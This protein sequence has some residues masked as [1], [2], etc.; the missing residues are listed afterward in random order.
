[1]HE[2]SHVLTFRTRD[3]EKAWEAF[4]RNP[5]RAVI[6]L[7]GDGT[8][9]EIVKYPTMPNVDPRY[10]PVLDR[11]IAQTGVTGM[12][13]GRSVEQVRSFGLLGEGLQVL[14]QFGCEWWHH[15]RL[16]LPVER[17]ATLDVVDAMLPE[18]FAKAGLADASIE[19]V[20]SH[21]RAIHYAAG[22]DDTTVA[23]LV[24]GL[25]HLAAKTGL[26]CLPG[27]NVIEL[28]PE[29]NKRDALAWF[30][31]ALPWEPSVVLYAGDS[32]PDLAAF[33]VLDGLRSQGVP[34]LKV[35][36]SDNTAVKARSDLLVRGPLGTL[37][38]LLRLCAL[39]SR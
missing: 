36:T 18:V 23:A 13:T 22:T 15:G 33:D 8:M 21:F 25:T 1:M 32:E 20:K 19:D 17:P 30:V 24:A 29:T 7:D 37:S 4:S 34:T 28:G 38:M 9:W 39:T 10:R 2:E 31:A 11:L 27:H 35:G 12:L 26:V 5:G 6:M 16:T 3:G 14:G